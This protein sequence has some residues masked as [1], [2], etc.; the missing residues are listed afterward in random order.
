MDKDKIA[1]L[2]ESGFSPRMSQGDWVWLHCGATIVIPDEEIDYVS[3]KELENKIRDLKLEAEG[4]LC[5]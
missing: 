4:F 3:S 1:L 5:A 2:K